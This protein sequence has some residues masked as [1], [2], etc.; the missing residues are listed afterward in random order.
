MART[1]RG[2]AVWAAIL[3]VVVLLAA[4]SVAAAQT[5]STKIGT[6]PLISPSALQ[7]S[8]YGTAVTNTFATTGRPREV[9]LLAQALRGDRADADFVDQVY[10][11]VRNNIEIAWMFGL[12]KGA[13]GAIIDHSGT[14]FDQ[15]HL[16]VEV[17]Q[18]GNVKA[19][20]QFGTITLTGAQFQQWSGITS[21][22]AA[23]QLLAAGGIPAAINGVTN[24][25][26]AGYGSQTVT[27]AVLSHIWV[28]ATINGTD[29]FFDPSYKAHDFKVQDAA[30]AAQIAAGGTIAAAAPADGG[31]ANGGNYVHALD[32]ALDVVR[33]AGKRPIH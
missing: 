8:A 21:A 23:C 17:L 5:P 31:T 4:P 2:G 20:Y 26:C 7:V 12:Q 33:V 18:Q 32:Q 15:A 30:L 10:D 19:G 13:L 24:A 9:V 16:M 25:T 14:S 6:A 27:S 28:K 29:Y 11:Y 22:T 1:W 3:G